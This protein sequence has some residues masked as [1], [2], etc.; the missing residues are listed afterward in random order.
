MS[1]ENFVLE[2]ADRMIRIFREF[3]EEGF[4]K[5]VM[6]GFRKAALPVK[7]AIIAG[8]PSEIAEVKKAVKVKSNMRLLV[9]SVGFFRNAGV[10]VNRR[11]IKWDPFQLAYWFN[12]GTYANRSPYHQFVRER[13]R[14]T[15]DRKGGIKPDLFVENAWENSKDAAARELE[16]EWARKIQELCDKY[17]ATK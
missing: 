15:R 8:I 12:Y 13:S 16:K 14:L 5:P 9:T 1:S 10:Y 17:G 4:N 11:G 3:P 6:D 7:K 2:G